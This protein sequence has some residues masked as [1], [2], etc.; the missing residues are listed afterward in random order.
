MVVVDRRKNRSASKSSY[1]LISKNVDMDAQPQPRDP[2]A[3]AMRVL[4]GHALE[5]AGKTVEEVGHNGTVSLV[6]IPDVCWVT[7]ALD[8]WKSWV[9]GGGSYCD[10]YRDSDFWRDD[11][12]IV[13]APVE[14]PGSSALRDSRDAFANA[15]S[16][17]QYC[18]GFASD[19]SWLP[20]DLVQATDHL[21]TLPRLS[22]ADI[23]AIACELCGD[24]S[25]E[26]VSAEQAVLV[27]PR[28][29]RLARRPGQTADAYIRKLREILEREHPDGTP[30]PATTASPRLDPTLERLHGVDEA[31][32]W[33][34]DVARD[35][36]A[37]KAGQLPW[38]GVDR[39]CLL[40]GPPGCGK[41]LFARALA[42]SCGVPLVSGSYGQWHGTGSA[43]Q[44]DLLKAMRRTFNDAR[45]AAPAILFIDE[46]DSFP[47][48]GAITHAY[49]EWEIQ[50]VNALLAEIDGVEGRE[51]VILLAACN[52]PDKLDPALVRSGRL[53]R[54]IRIHMPD[55]N[56]LESIFR[57][58]VGPDDLTGVSL[59]GAALAA[60]GSSGADCERFV[61]GA[62]RRARV[63]G[64]AMMLSDLLEEIG[65]NDPRTE[66]ELRIAAIHEAGHALAACELHPGS[67]RAVTL[68][69]SGD[70]GGGAVA[71]IPG[72]H[73]L[74]IDVNRRLTFLL[75]GR[76]AEDVI[77]GAPSSG[78]GGHAES[79]LAMATRLAAKAAASFG[80]D[81]PTGLVWS[82]V[83]DVSNLP[84][85]L[86]DDSNLTPGCG[87]HSTKHIETRSGWCG[88]V[89]LRSR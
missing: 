38:E 25:R 33:G 53:D 31:V 57:E 39:G 63:A 44:G 32:A 82:G 47:N 46:I 13:W 1:P 52:H 84:Q 16:K 51:G 60:A 26:S 89:E 56:A 5:A 76:A 27:T 62:R 14:A 34:L 18:S 8:E 79:D 2:A 67:L 41:T 73:L 77:L 78:A 15:I 28:L 64:R 36:Q 21:L 19:I 20:V 83:P 22:A 58:H 50:V 72:R 3:V 69:P 85:M 70:T 6:L 66:A 80:L 54:H 30:G 75:A 74:A 4:I 81:A 45:S 86:A 17:G 68:R 10:G 24:S 65:G 37:F 88:G 11:R 59:A 48:R 40:S 23:T 61:R 42:A 71:V 9:R 55:Q 12:W 35:L 87:W 49:A 43:H 7:I 29:L